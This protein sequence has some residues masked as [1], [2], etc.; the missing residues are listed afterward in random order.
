MET[1]QATRIQTSVLNGVEKKVLIWIANRLPQWVT[2]DMMTVVGILGSCLVFTGFVL[3]N[4]DLN[5]LWLSS[6]G[7]IVNWFGDSLD[8]TIARVR[9]QQRPKYGYYLDH[10]VDVVCEGL[11]FVGAGLS[12]I[13]DLPLA[14]MCFILYL[15]MTVYVTINAHLKSE[16]KLTYAALGPTEFRIL[17][18]LMNLTYLYIAPLH[19]WCAG[20]CDIFGHTMY[21]T[22]TNIFALIILVLLVVIY[23]VSFLKDLNYFAELEPLD[24]ARKRDLTQEPTNAK[25]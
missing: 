25:E 12:P 9:R 23:I 15:A 7:L 20:T 5:W 14:L 2:S 22:V 11:M 16:F 18:I 1:K 19:T 10:N 17:V 21:I 13:F 3:S 6:G 24:E 4:Y 8:G